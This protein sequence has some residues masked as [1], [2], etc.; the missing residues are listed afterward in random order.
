MKFIPLT[1]GKTALID[2]EDFELVSEYKWYPLSTSAGL[3]Y[4]NGY[5]LRN[6]HRSVVLMHRLLMNAQPGQG[7]DHRNRNGLD[8]R[9]FNLRFATRSQN[10]INRISKRKA[11]S[12]FKGVHW[13][14][15]N[16]KWVARVRY[17]KQ[18]FHIGYFRE[19]KAAALAYDAAVLKICP[20]YARLNFPQLSFLGIRKEGK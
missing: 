14:K 9:R 10:A 19:E 18:E 1:Q 15:S 2:D 16:R 7:I 12:R 5:L 6:G 8:N 4:A 11:S 3:V 13:H 17:G 20:D